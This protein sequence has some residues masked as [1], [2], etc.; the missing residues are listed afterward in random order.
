MS[1]PQNTTCPIC[2]SKA[3]LSQKIKSTY[4]FR[5]IGCSHCFSVFAEGS[6]LSR[7]DEKI[8]N[9]SYYTE[10]HVNWFKNPDFLLYNQILQHMHANS[11]NYSLLDVGC[12]TGS[13]LQFI[14]DR[15]WFSLSRLVGIDLAATP[16]QGE[17]E[18]INADVNEYI[19]DE[20]FDYIVSLAVVEHISDVRG[21]LERLKTLTNENGHIVLMTLNENSILYTY[22]KALRFFGIQTPMERLYDSHHIHHFTA[23][24]LE[25]LVKRTPG[26][27]V[28]KILYHNIP[29]KS[30]DLPYKS[31]FLRHLA[32]LTVWVAFLLGK[33]FVKK[34]YL[35]TIFCLKE[36]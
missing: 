16:M 20:K 23:S 10:K 6:E 8:Y 15:R 9:E 33:I 34:A 22:A 11:P 24:S 32:K 29:M 18:I 17:V 12:G 5:C 30:V 31:P 27:A 21:F 25:E 13:F 26:L 4:I 35:Q 1:L 14:S 19:F 28:E 2:G 3:N 36:K 7:S